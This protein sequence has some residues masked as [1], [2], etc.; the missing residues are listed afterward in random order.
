MGRLAIDL[1]ITIRPTD[2]DRRPR[3][4]AQAILLA[5]IPAAPVVWA[6]S[7]VLVGSV[8]GA[9]SGESGGWAASAAW[10]VQG[11][12]AAPAGRPRHRHWPPVLEA[13]DAPL[14]PRNCRPAAQVDQAAPARANCLPTTS[15]TGRRMPIGM[16]IER[17]RRLAPRARPRR[18]RT[19]ST[20]TGPGTCTGR[21]REATGIGGLRRDGKAPDGT[22]ERAPLRLVAAAT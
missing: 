8:E 22:R 2:I 17:L 11:A 21:I 10:G 7:A 5:A 14:P 19:T 4:T 13:A 1:P 12:P 16:R 6:A 3:V 9:A 20:A 15:T 18:V